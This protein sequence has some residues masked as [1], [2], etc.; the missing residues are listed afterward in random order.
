MQDSQ[1]RNEQISEASIKSIMFQALHA[2]HY[3]HQNGFMHR[4]IKPENFLI[5]K[6]ESQSPEAI[7]IKLADFGLAKNSR[8]NKG[9]HTDYVSTRWYR[10]PELC[11]RSTQY[12]QSVDIFALGCIMAELYLGRPLFPG[13]SESD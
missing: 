11:L 6:G 2:V 13:Q 7:Q 3:V 1:R 9:P 4:D 10:A 8:I 5:N 12:S